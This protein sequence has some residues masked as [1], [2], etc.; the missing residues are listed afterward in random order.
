MNRNPFDCKATLPIRERERAGM[1]FSVG[2]L[3]LAEFKNRS[4]EVLPYARERNMALRLNFRD[5]KCLLLLSLS[6]FVWLKEN[7][8]YDEL[9][10][11]ARGKCSS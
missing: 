5:G 10:Q 9:T 6:S 2:E 11:N 1:P 3:D 8:R 7:G 4:Q